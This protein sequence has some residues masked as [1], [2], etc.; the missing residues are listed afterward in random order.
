MNE[1]ATYTDRELRERLTPEQYHVTQEKG[2]ERAF[3]GI[4]WDNHERGMYHCIVCDTPLFASET[5]FESGC[6]WPSFYQPTKDV[7]IK[8]SV[9]TSFSMVRKEITC[10]TCGAH[11]GHVFDDGPPPTHLRYCINSASLSFKPAS[12]TT[13]E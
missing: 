5:K 11:L 6:G 8:E 9:D 13:A 12:P 3:T 7:V 2:T 10:A 1:K 4:Y